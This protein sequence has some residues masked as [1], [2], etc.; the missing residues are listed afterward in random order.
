[1]NE[2][3]DR[4]NEIAMKLLHYFIT[5]QNYNPIILQ[6]AEDEIWLENLQGEYKIIRIVSGHVHNKEQLEFDTFKTKRVVKK[7][8]RKTFC[9]DMKVLSIFTDLGDNVKFEE[10]DDIDS[11]Y[12]YETE[13]IK[14]YDFVKEVFPDIV[15]KLK[16]SEEGVKLF[17]KITSDI[18]RKN[19]K[20]AEIVNDV[21]KP[22]RPIVTTVLIFIN[23]AIFLLELFNPGIEESFAVWNIGIIKFNQFYRLFTGIFL[24]ANIWHLLTNMYALYVIGSQLEGFIGR[25]KYLTVYIV[26]GIM[27]S[28][29]SVALHSGNFAAVVASGAIFGLLGSILYFGYHYRVY[30]GEVVK[31]QIIPIIVINLIIGFSFSGIDNFGHIGGLIGGVLTTMAVGIKHKSTTSDRINGIIISII[32]FVFL[33]YLMMMHNF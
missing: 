19:K 33:Y 6:G 28:L 2:L 21:F 29:L 12:L 20:E 8:K 23:I 11:I 18:N 17:M 26:S 14:K 15:K 9:F 5:E 22:K 24:H 32:I 27:G 25:A 31:T 30:L 3:L 16:F 13:D 1:M 10:E 4:K 7:I